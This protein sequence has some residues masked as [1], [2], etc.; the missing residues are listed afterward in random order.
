MGLQAEIEAAAVLFSFTT[1]TI[2]SELAEP[3]CD[4]LALR[5]RPSA[6]S[7]A[8]GWKESGVYAASV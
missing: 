5:R 3:V 7:A 4:L 1:L 6:L 8:H 2:L